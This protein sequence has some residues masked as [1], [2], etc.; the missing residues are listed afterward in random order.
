MKIRRYTVGGITYT[1][2]VPGGQQS[3]SSGSSSGSSSSGDKDS[4]EKITG[5][6]KKEIVDILKSNGLP[7]D[8][9]AFLSNANAFLT[10]SAS[11]SNMSLFG[12]TNN[13]YDLSELIRIQ[14][15]ASKAAWNKGKYDEAV[16][17]L[18]E[19]DA[20]GE[21]AT[22]SSGRLYIIDEDG[23]FSTIS[24]DKFKADKHTAITNEQL[25]A[26]REQ[27]PQ[28]AMNSD[29]LT[30]LGSTVGMKTIQDY[31]RTLASELGNDTTVSYASKK[32]KQVANGIQALMEA[33]PDGYYKITNE[34]QARDI[35]VALEYLYQ[36]LTPKMKRTLQA[37]VVANGGDIT[38]DTVRFIGMIL[39]NNIDTKLSVD[40]DGNFDDTTGGKRSS[41]SSGSS[42]KQVPKTLSELYAT[43]EGFE[44]S[45]TPIITKEG[46]VPMSVFAQNI[47]PVLDK[48]GELPLGD[49]NVEVL[50]HTAYGIGTIVD[51]NSI[52]FGD[53]SIS[54]DDA[55]K[56]MYESK[57]DMYRVYMPAKEDGTGRI[58]PDFV[59]HQQIEAI[60][61]KTEGMTEGQIQSLI[62]DIDG[63]H[64]DTETKMVVADNVQLFLT[65]GAIASDDAMGKSLKS[66]K[67]LKK[68]SEQ[69]EGRKKK[70]YN[71]AVGVSYS[72]DGENNREDSGNP[73]TTWWWGY[74]FYEG[75][76]FI[77]MTTSTTAAAIHNEFLVPQSNYMNVGAK[78]QAHSE[79][80]IKDAMTG[81]AI[82]NGDLRFNF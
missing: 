18:K 51:R 81:Q 2:F 54:W 10:E 41:S 50:L 58:R 30:G 28:F 17:K 42:E 45:W 79:Q 48:N 3:A 32:G 55:T 46:Q 73:K 77:P 39:T 20:W 52:T 63:V 27:N 16:E 5:T 26:L 11:L 36:N 66:S 72:I 9:D 49:A 33:G 38:K 61:A 76:V 68:I 67:Y 1:P 80:Q 53:I 13:D 35:N 78:Q 47:G 44:S 60:N 43:G 70:K 8:V 62:K 37:T 23:Q 69:D 7:S 59:L 40:H 71:T 4:P 15:M 19:Q 65:F 75:N 34:T 22:D 82:Q 12:G 14:S 6:I 64:Y 57:N 24:P 56:L 29:I 21:V 31:L 74:N 25:L